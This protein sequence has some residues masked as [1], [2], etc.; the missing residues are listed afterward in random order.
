M[1]LNKEMEKLIS[2]K[3]PTYFRTNDNTDPPHIVDYSAALLQLKKSYTLKINFKILPKENT[4]LSIVTNFNP[5][6]EYAV[7]GRFPFFRTVHFLSCKISVVVENF[8]PV[9]RKI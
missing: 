1:K 3:L 2:K 9:T 7:G 6:N 4:S 5:G 8:P